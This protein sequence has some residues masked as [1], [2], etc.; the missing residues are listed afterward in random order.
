MQYADI[1]VPRGEYTHSTIHYTFCVEVVHSVRMFVD[2]LVVWCV[3][4]VFL[5]N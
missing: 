5:K 1:V 2:F 3:A 4:N